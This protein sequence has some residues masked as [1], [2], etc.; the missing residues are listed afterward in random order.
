M[1]RSVRHNAGNIGFGHNSVTKPGTDATG[2][3]SYE[4]SHCGDKTTGAVI[5]VV[6]GGVH[7]IRWLQCSTCH[8]PTIIDSTGAQH[9][10]VAFGPVLQGLPKDV[11]AAYQEARRCLAINA[12]VAA[13]GMCRKIL[14][15][16]AVEKEAKEGG[17]FGGYIEHLAKQGYVT[18]PMRPWVDLIRRHGN[19]A[20]HRL[21]PPDRKRAEATLLF[22][23]HLLR[24]VYEMEHLA[25]E[26][27][28]PAPETPQV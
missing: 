27:I 14:M 24:N 5:A 22:T 2:W 12:D 11:E 1:L 26:Y 15:H 13:E 9:P 28:L 6:G 20:N 8:E 18:P 19:E 10:G 16:V 4:C 23:A 7:P 21:D 25:G 3:W 17:N